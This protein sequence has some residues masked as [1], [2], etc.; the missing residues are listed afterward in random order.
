L[1]QGRKSLI[2]RQKRGIK[3]YKGKIIGAKR[4]RH[5]F[6][7]SKEDRKGYLNLLKNLKL[8]GIRTKKRYKGGLKNLKSRYRK[9]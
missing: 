3:V 6:D 9:N 5:M 1:I 2:A 4:S 8:S 7:N